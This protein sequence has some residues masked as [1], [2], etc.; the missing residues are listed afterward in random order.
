M[1][2]KQTSRFTLIVVFKFQWVDY[3]WEENDQYYEC[4]QRD[5]EEPCQHRERERGGGERGHRV[6]PL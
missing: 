4:T 3:V 6:F 2:L 1:I 5:R